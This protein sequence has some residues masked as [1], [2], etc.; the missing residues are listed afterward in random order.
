M[1]IRNK[2]WKYIDPSGEYEKTELEI[3]AEY[4]ECWS[5]K[6]RKNGRE[7]LISEK[8]CID[9]WVVTNWAWEVKNE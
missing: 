4:F 7:D 1:V 9:D 2:K 3:L 6:M 5:A 8:R